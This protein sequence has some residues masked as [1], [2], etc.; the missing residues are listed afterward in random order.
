MDTIVTRRLRRALL[1]LPLVLSGCFGGADFGVDPGPSPGSQPAGHLYVL[2]SGLNR[3]DVVDETTGAILNSIAVGDRPARM[4]TD[5]TY[6]DDLF[7]ADQ[8]ADALSV[9]DTA[10]ETVAHT[11]AVGS[12]PTDV[13]YGASG[14]LRVLNAGDATVTDIDIHTWTPD[15]TYRVGNG[16]TSIADD[17]IG[18]TYVTNAGDG[19]VTIIGDSGVAATLQ[20]GTRP[21][22]VTIGIDEAFVGDT[23]D[24]SIYALLPPQNLGQPFGI[25]RQD[26][27]VSG[28]TR[29]TSLDK[30]IGEADCNDCGVGAF[31]PDAFS[32][33]DGFQIL[34]P[35]GTGHLPAPTG[36]VTVGALPYDAT[37]D[38][39]DYDASTKRYFVTN[40]GDD[41]ISVISGGVVI[42]TIHLP[43]GARPTSILALHVRRPASPTPAPT[44]TPT[45]TTTP[46]PGPGA[47]PASGTLYVADQGTPQSVTGFALPLSA[48]S[49]PAF[50][51]AEVTPP[52]GI[53]VDA[54]HGLIA[55]QYTNGIVA[56]ERLP[57]GAAGGT[58]VA[59]IANAAGGGTGQLAFDASGDLFAGTLGSAVNEYAPPFADGQTPSKV[60]SGGG[61]AVSDGVAVD[62]S[63]VL[64]AANL[65]DGVVTAFAPPYA[66]GV[67]V[68]AAGG[69]IPSLVVDGDRLYAAVASGQI[70]V[71]ALPLSA[72][73]T[74]LF[75]LSTPQGNLEGIAFDGA[76]D[77]YVTSANGA[78]FVYA[79][80][81]GGSSTPALTLTAGLRSPHQPA[82]GP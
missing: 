45:A 24:G 38:E 44:A 77:M 76:G 23:S 18:Y 17:S 34:A 28:L 32:Y 31:G 33:F 79:A 21:S 75:T 20:V 68:T 15:A 65:T 27:T 3:V 48:S 81:V 10:T 29:L 62:G 69:P 74:P 4:T 1:P 11:I 57:F 80:P 12:Q 70:A 5:P 22:T 7:V 16:P 19:T 25:V 59:T 43:A 56:I 14:R 66:T 13:A 36:T 39:V 50:A 72:A 42:Y 60:I 6:N 9:I 8:N 35:G 71:F 61:L 64:Y 67:S 52:L 78:I 63:G 54:S 53:A 73:S 26:P 58:L 37:S 30:A 47:S 41:S 82:V 49:I 51:S 40:Y 46:T 55:I 2:E